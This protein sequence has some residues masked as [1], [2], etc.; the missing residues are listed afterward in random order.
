M[1]NHSRHAREASG[2]GPHIQHCII[3]LPLNI[4]NDE[5]WFLHRH[6]FH[7]TIP[8]HVVNNA[9]LNW[10]NFKLKKKPTSKFIRNFF[11]VLSWV[12]Q[13]ASNQQPAIIISKSYYM[14][15]FRFSWYTFCCS[16]SLEAIILW[17][18]QSQIWC[19]RVIS[20][21]FHR[22]IIGALDIK[23]DFFLPSILQLHKRQEK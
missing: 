9:I 17:Y 13:P 2:K 10:N 11:F 19:T 3:S 20:F 4:L 6:K 15:I 23:F 14:L 18:I 8:F 12:E 7:K 5:Y 16:N 1:N 21:H 22:L